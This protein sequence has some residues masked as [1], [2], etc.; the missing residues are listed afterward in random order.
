MEVILLILAIDIGNTNMEF[1]LF[2][3][4]QLINNF[5]LV[6]DRNTTSD[7]IGLMMLQFF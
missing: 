1:G 7:E 3:N 6:T 4:S 2:E 5:R